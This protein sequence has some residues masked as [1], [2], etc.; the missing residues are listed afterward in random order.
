MR[1]EILI[2]KA[3]KNWAVSSTDPALEGN[4]VGVTA[5]TREEAIDEFKKSLSVYLDY[6]Q[7]SG[8][9][10]PQVTEFE[11]RELIPAS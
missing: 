10:V 1:I 9:E 7:S 6:L 4:F 8:R 11:V 2:E 3:E 5:D